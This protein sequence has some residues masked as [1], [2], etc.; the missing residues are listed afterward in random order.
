MSRPA[1]YRTIDRPSG[2]FLLKE[3]KSKFLG[4]VFPAS[5]PGEAASQIDTLWKKYPD[6]THICYAYRI[7]VENPM[8][9]M[10]DDG[11]PAYSAGAPIYNQIESEQLFDV[12]LC[13]IRYYGGTKLGV[14]GLI[15]AYREAA[16]GVLE[17][18]RVVNRV[19]VCKLTLDFEYPLL[20]A[21]M[22]FVS[23]HQLKLR[24]QRMELDCSLELEVP[25]ERCGEI[26]EG[27]HGLGG[28]KVRRE[29]GY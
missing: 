23:Q 9:R 17:Q 29:T 7:G 6:A 24:S 10:N 15:Q 28:V 27:I 22:R 26:L 5:N 1:P 8:V 18:A 19:P 14:G 2:P 25:L 12:L 4:W 21:V 11:E 16:R 3:R 13:V 20:D